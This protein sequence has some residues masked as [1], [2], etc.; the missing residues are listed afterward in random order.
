MSD[1]ELDLTGFSYWDFSYN[2]Y[3]YSYVRTAVDQYGYDTL[4]IDRLGIGQS[5]LFTDPVNE[6]QLWLEVAA[7]Q[8]ITQDARNGQIAGIQCNSEKIV[9]VG[10]SFGSSLTYSLTAM[11]PSLSDGIVLTGFSQNGTFASQFLLGSNFIIANTVPA[12]SQ[13]PTGY[14]APATVE[15]V[16]I[17]F[18]APGD[19]DPNVLATAYATGQPVTPGEL[20]TLTGSSAKPNTF[21]GPVLVITGEHDTPYC[22]GDCYATGSPALASIPAASA[23]YIPNAAPFEAF[24]VPGAGHGLN[25]QYTYPTTYGTI[26]NFL[27]QNGLAAQ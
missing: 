17:D 26:L 2:N 1:D 9:H 27:A 24:I 25:L 23:Q 16:Q 5:T 11:D 19:F 21:A 8:L 13:Y 10:H 22:G 20:L 6:G 15:G 3:N 7:L 4:A 18:F 14:L 12:L